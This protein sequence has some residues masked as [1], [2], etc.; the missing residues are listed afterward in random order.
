MCNTL[1][2]RILI[3]IF[4]VFVYFAAVQ[5]YSLYEGSF[6]GSIAASQVEDSSEVVAQVIACSNDYPQLLFF[7]LAVIGLASIWVP[8]ILND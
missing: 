2:G 7:I 3:S 5:T 1:R 4:V 6:E 8:Y